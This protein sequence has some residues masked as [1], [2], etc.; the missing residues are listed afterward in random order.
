MSCMK[1]LAMHHLYINHTS[2]VMGLACVWLSHRHADHVLG[3]DQILYHRAA[4]AQPLL[5]IGPWEVGRWLD[6]MKEANPTWRAIFLHC[7]YDANAYF[8]NIFIVIQY[9]IHHTLYII[10]KPFVFRS[11]NSAQSRAK[12]ASWMTGMTAW[13]SVPVVHCRQVI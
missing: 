8:G 13:C 11:F 7:G 4:D 6:K 12:S 1:V 2:Q 10:F 9:F 5:V 3:L